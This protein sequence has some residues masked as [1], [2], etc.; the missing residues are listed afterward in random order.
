MTAQDTRKGKTVSLPADQLVPAFSAPHNASTIPAGANTGDLRIEGCLTSNG[1]RTGAL[2]PMRVF[3]ANNDRAQFKWSDA[4]I[5]AAP[6][7][8]KRILGHSQEKDNASTAI[9]QDNLPK[10]VSLLC[11]GT[12]LPVPLERIGKRLGQSKN[13]KVT[14]NWY[15]DTGYDRPLALKIIECS[16]PPKVPMEKAL[17]E[18][19]IMQHLAHH[20]V[21]SYVASYEATN[22]DQDNNPEDQVLGI[23]M[24]PPGRCDLEKALKAISD[25]YNP[26][27]TRALSDDCLKLLRS[28][29][30]FFGCLSQALSY[31][32][33]TD[34][35]IKH[36]D[37]KPANIIID[38]FGEPI[39]TDFGISK[40]YEDKD[41]VSTQGG[42][43]WTRKYAPPEAY[44]RGET[45][46][47]RADV[48]S[49]GCVF[50]ELLTVLLG[51]TLKDLHAHMNNKP[52]YCALDEVKS[53]LTEK[54]PRSRKTTTANCRALHQLLNESRE[55]IVEESGERL[56]VSARE[57]LIGASD[58]ILKML[59]RSA[60]SRPNASDLFAMF[61]PLYQ[62]TKDHRACDL[63]ELQDQTRILP[64]VKEGYVPPMQTADYPP[65]INRLKEELPSSEDKDTDSHLEDSS[66]NPTRRASTDHVGGSIAD[67][68]QP[69]NGA[70]VGVPS[71]ECL[72]PGR[73]LRRRT[74]M[75][76]LASASSPDSRPATSII[77]TNYDKA[78]W[79]KGILCYKIR[80]IRPNK[81]DHEVYIEHAELEDG[82]RTSRTVK[83]Q[84]DQSND[85][86][87]YKGPYS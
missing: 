64:E 41:Q 19:A 20:H 25:E 80:P 15:P 14:L 63:C 79:R 28:M 81:Y 2:L 56:Y 13:T 75:P 22:F 43:T 39:I 10:H 61:E 42:S 86:Q 68:L 33:T 57:A 77:V 17:V 50:L 66:P 55:L 52:Y 5:E 54:L 31:L 9:N 65:G 32:H 44:S 82:M 6:A 48:F 71:A 46:G 83:E 34:V 47:F 78:R 29:F 70:P 30:G 69:G 76:A 49:L 36:K 58:T 72:P 24:Y 73:L 45:C 67:S 12:V 7:S 60:D 26:D 40:R 18:V 84:T 21:V 85:R 16:A 74:S 1:T 87:L 37:I 4:D 59:S 11:S 23:I 51:E 8:R 53:W 38:A 35:I 3:I 62:Y 27:C